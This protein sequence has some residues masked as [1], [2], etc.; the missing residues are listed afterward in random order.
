MKKRK[1]ILCDIS[2]KIL[3]AGLPVMLVY[4]V[5]LFISISSHENTSRDVLVHLYAPQLEYILMS[6]TLILLAALLFDIAEKDYET[7]KK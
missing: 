7:R 2:T 3:Y 5:Y 4:F 1:Y 6:L